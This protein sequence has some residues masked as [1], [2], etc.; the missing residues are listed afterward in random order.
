MKKVMTF[1]IILSVLLISNVYAKCDYKELAEL[2]QD[3][4]AIKIMYEEDS[5]F[6]ISNEGNQ[7]EYNFLKM[8]IINMNDNFYIKATNTKEKGETLYKY[9]GANDGI[10]SFDMKDLSEVVTYTFKVYSSS[11]TNCKNTLIRTIYVTVPRYN[12]Y[13]A[14]EICDGVENS[15]CDKYVMSD[16]IPYLDFMDKIEKLKEEGKIKVDDKEKKSGED[17]NFGLIIGI[18]AGVVVLITTIV[19]ITRRKKEML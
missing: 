9:T 8:N 13:S 11:N 1:F 10:L 12:L 3:A 14:Y 5:D 6:S 15:L 2:N 18:S 7:I 17:I 16:S 4:G 19:I